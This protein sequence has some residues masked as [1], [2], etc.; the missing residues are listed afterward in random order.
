[1]PNQYT[2][3][4]RLGLPKP[5]IS[6]ETRQKLSVATSKSLQIRYQNPEYRKKLSESMK[7]AVEKFPES[8]GVSNR[9][10]TRKIEA[11]G[12]SFQGKWELDFFDYCLQNRIEVR[13]CTEGFQYEWNG[14]RKYFPDFFLPK[15]QTYIE[16][17]GYETARDL[18]KWKNFPSKIKVIRRKQIEDIRRKEFDLITFIGQAE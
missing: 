14:S 1:M 2:K 16:I 6:E 5:E 17:K 8:Y 15:F 9:G 3:A 12:L 10:R 4:Q 18:A 11:H 13:R 7:R